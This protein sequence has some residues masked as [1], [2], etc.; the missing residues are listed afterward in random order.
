M[1]IADLHYGNDECAH[2]LSGAKKFVEIAANNI[3]A[4]REKL[5]LRHL[6][7][8]GHHDCCYKKIADWVKYNLP[9]HTLHLLTQYFPYNIETNPTKRT[10]QIDEINRALNYAESIGLHVKTLNLLR[11]NK[12]LQQEQPHIQNITITEDGT[13]AFKY[14]TKAA[15]ETAYSIGG[16]DHPHPSLP[17]RGRERKREGG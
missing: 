11:D 13:V 14:I 5:I 1:I 4:V 8:P 16:E 12:D 15:L 7:L 3:A 9:E 10:L 17:L 6:L 2:N